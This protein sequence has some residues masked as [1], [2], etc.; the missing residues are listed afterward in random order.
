MEYIDSTNLIKRKLR[1]E[2]GGEDALKDGRGRKKAPEELQGLIAKNLRSRRWNVKWS[3]FGLMKLKR[4]Q[5]V[6]RRERKRYTRSTPQQVAENVL[7]RKF[8]AEAP[9]K[10]WVTD[11]KRP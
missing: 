6:I 1:F 5:S 7:S 9:N 11:A 8:T 3:G 4:I 10:K 2:D